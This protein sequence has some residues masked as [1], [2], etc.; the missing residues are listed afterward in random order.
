MS[1]E[2]QSIATNNYIL[3]TQQEVSHD[4][5]LSGTGMA[6]SPLG[7]ILSATNDA[8]VNNIVVTA[9]LPDTPDANT[10]YLIPEA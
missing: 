10:L 7:V 8:N 4:N 9:A 3:A 1:N 5:T 2:I 6:D